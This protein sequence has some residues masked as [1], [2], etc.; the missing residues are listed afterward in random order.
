MAA[1]L[2]G[3]LSGVLLDKLGRKCTI[4]S[5]NILGLISWILLAIASK[6]DNDIMFIQLMASRFLVGKI[7]KAGAISIILIICYSR[8]Y[9]WVI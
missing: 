3:L 8:C 9:P 7:L 5:L 1:P 4:Y 6:E 2:G